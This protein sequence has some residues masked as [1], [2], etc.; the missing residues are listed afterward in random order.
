M[1]PR[2]TILQQRGAGRFPAFTPP[3]GRCTLAGRR[4]ASALVLAEG[5]ETAIFGS[6]F[7]ALHR[8]SRSLADYIQVYDGILPE[9]RCR[10]L[11]DRFEAE[12]QSQ[13]LTP[14]DKSFPFVELNISWHWPEVH[15]EIE[16]LMMT[17]F[18][19]YSQALQIGQFWP[20]KAD[21]EQ[22]RLKRYMP[23]GEDKF[24]P[25]VDVMEALES[26]RFITAILYL[27][28]PGGGETVFPTLDISVTP[29]PGR[30]VVFPPLWLFP[31]AGLPPRDQPKYILHRYL[32]YPVG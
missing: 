16:V 22:M 31:H 20:A 32:L 1:R 26:R 13:R 7:L 2:S 10:E 15:G 3:T 21:R 27:N 6:P 14:A 11:I 24:P 8:L 25:H 4:M 28:E 29:A 19:R 18:R 5:R 12:P 9:A 17:A 30:M 23:G